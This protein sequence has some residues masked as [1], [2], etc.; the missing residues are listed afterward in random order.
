VTNYQ[1]KILTIQ[2]QIQ[3]FIDAGMGVS[4]MV[5][6]KNAM[7]TIG[8]YR[9]R[10][11]CFHKYDNSTKKYISGTNLMD[12]LRLYDFDTELSHLLFSMT[13]SIEVALRVRLKEALL[14]YNDPLILNN[15]SEFVIEHSPQLKQ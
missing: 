4:D 7:E 11:Y 3:A 10:G 1:K 6:A 2:Q 13:S 8:Y 12:V 15:P 9:L 5:G 14:M